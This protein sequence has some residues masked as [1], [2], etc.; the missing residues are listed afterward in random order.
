MT[1]AQRDRR[2]AAHPTGAKVTFVGAGP[3]AADLLTVRGAQAIADA[4]VVIWAAS[5]VHE[6]VLAHAQADAQI[7]DSSA[8]TLEEM[9]E[10]YRLA[11]DRG[12]HVVRLHSGDPSLYGAMQEQIDAVEEVGLPWQ[13]IPGVSSLGAA[14]AALGRELTVPEVA[15]SV[16]VTRFATRTPMPAG[17]NLRAFAAHRTTLALFLSAARPRRVQEELLVGGY[18]PST[19]CAV[20]YRAT[21]PDER[22]LRCRLG[23]LGR[24]VR[25]A[26]LTKHALILVGRALEVRGTRSRL[27]SPTFSHSHRQAAP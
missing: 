26:G 12:E 8:V 2:A 14:A 3:G 11:V 4:D 16:I 17:E 20:V 19:P 24:T 25:D 18:P 5:L 22:V 27:Y 13:I 15:Q 10:R 1:D 9:L 7:L 23:D 6:G 21:W